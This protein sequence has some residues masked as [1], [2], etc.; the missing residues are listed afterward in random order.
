MPTAA[1]A[2]ATEQVRRA[3]YVPGTDPTAIR[4]R[5]TGLTI[6]VQPGAA[7]GTG[8][9]TPSPLLSAGSTSVLN[10]YGAVNSGATAVSLGGGSTVNNF[11]TSDTLFGVITGDVAFGAT[12]GSEVN[13]PQQSRLGL[14]RHRKYHFVRSA[15][16]L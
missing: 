6:D 8:S 7:V 3:S 12:T 5:R 16:H 2:D 10:N 15:V 13:T 9:A 1:F 11:T 4:P 14:R